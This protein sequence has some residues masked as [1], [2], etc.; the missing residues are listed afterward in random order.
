[1]PCRHIV[2]VVPARAEVEPPAAVTVNTLYNINA[3][4]IFGGAEAPLGSGHGLG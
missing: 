1:M 4:P 2:I 3:C